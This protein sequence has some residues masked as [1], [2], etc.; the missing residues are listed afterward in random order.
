MKRL[1]WGCLTVLLVA[2]AALAQSTID[3]T[4]EADGKTVLWFAGTH[5]TALIESG[6]TV[7]G[8]L[9]IEGEIVDFTAAGTAT[10]EGEGDSAALTLDV[11]LLFDAAGE[12]TDGIPISLRG[13]MAGSSKDTDLA[14]SAFGSATG[15][16]FFVVSLG[17][18]TYWALGT[19]EGSATGAFVVPDDPLTMQMEGV[20]NYALLGELTPHPS[21]PD[22]SSDME[23]GLP[24]DPASW[25]AELYEDLIDLLN[26]V[27]D[28]EEET[29]AGETEEG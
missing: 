20:G 23:A 28:N 17:P 15:P 7:D 21:T 18:D 29:A 10:G 22:D 19:A 16:F 11:W 26:G 2:G 12:T 13:G 8:S 9:D 25:P 5:V 4:G 3:A 14:S 24:W 27:C 6:F 1:A